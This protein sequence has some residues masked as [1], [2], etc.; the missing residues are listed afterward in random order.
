MSE[1]SV[2]IPFTNDRGSPSN[3]LVEQLT[4]D[5]VSLKARHQMEMQSVKTELNLARQLLIKEGHY[6]TNTN[7]ITYCLYYSDISTVSG[8]SAFRRERLNVEPLKEEYLRDSEVA[9]N[10]MR[11]V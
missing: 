10:E 2:Y 8:V 6:I 5:I 9:V 1:P 11:Y 7:C 3:E 4:K